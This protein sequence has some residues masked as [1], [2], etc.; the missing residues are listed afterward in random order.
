VTAGPAPIILVRG[1]HA[2]AFTEVLKEFGSPMR[3][4]HRRFSLPDF[5]SILPDTYVPVR[6]LLRCFDY[7]EQKEGIDDLG[8]RVAQRENF[9]RLSDELVGISRSAPTLFA[10]LTQFARLAPLENT[11]IRVSHSREGEDFR[12]AVNLEGCRELQGLRLSEWVQLF[13]LFDLVRKSTSSDWLPSEITFQSRFTPARNVLEYFHDTR[14]LVGQTNTSIKVPVS[15]VQK[16][17]LQQDRSGTWCC[18]DWNADTANGVQTLDFPGTLDLALRTY[19]RD[20]YP[21]IQLAAEIA[22]TSVRTLQRRLA[23]FGLSYAALV[24]QARFAVAA[25]L[26]RDPKVKS[27]EVAYEVGYSDPSNFARAFRQVAGVSPEEYRRQQN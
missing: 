11:Y 19:L 5:E 14:I 26:L 27:Y 1:A 2:L 15:L 17:P 8:F 18:P 21:D 10:R 3:D 22:G 20:G 16:I 24:L 9:E 23:S 6:P 4:V 12:I 13:V 25:E 7:M